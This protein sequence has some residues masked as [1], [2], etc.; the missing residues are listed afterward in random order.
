MRIADIP[1]G[2]TFRGGIE[3]KAGQPRYGL[4][5]KREELVVGLDHPAWDAF[6]HRK[7]IDYRPVKLTFTE[8][9]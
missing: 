7:V 5:L 2:T 9:E 4:W 8:V 3:I 6:C 1:D